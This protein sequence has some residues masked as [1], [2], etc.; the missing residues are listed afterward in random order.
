MSKSETFSNVFG[1]IASIATAL[2]VA[3]GG[4]WAY[5]QFFEKRESYPKAEIVHNIESLALPENRI[6]I[7]IEASVENTGT[8]ALSLT[9]GV[10]RVESV[11]PLSKSV[12]S[13]LKEYSGLNSEGQTFIRWPTIATRELVWKPGEFEI[14]PGETDHA[15]YEFVVPAEQQV[16]NVYSF[17]TN[18]QKTETGRHLGW[19]RSTL[20]RISK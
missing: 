9:S 6:L 13:S 20:Y 14:E 18:D 15:Y 16:I 1:G 11:L 5:W 12:A 19:S 8:T 10:V 4:V 3:A 7:R 2:G 17:L